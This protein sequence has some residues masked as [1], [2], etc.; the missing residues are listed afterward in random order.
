MSVSLDRLVRNQVVFR[1]V[2]DRIKEVLDR[3]DGAVLRADFVC[4]CSQ[5][6]CVESI[7]LELDEYR[8][9][10]SSPRLFVITPGHEVSEVE[11]VI[12]TNERFMLVEKT[13]HVELVEGSHSAAHAS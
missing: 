6:D 3:L 11:D 4:E 10:R 5:A 2:N 7:E 8:A 9:I 12:E 13:R 1:E